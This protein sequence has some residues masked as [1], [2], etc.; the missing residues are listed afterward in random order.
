MVAQLWEQ[1]WAWQLGLLLL[2]ITLLPPSRPLEGLH[3]A[4]T[5]LSGSMAWPG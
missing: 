3:G 4:H 1:N 2:R 5:A